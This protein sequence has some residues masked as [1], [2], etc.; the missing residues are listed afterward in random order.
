MAEGKTISCAC[1]IITPTSYS[2]KKEVRQKEK[3]KQKKKNVLKYGKL[4]KFPTFQHDKQTTSYLMFI[5]KKKT[6]IV[7]FRINRIYCIGIA[8]FTHKSV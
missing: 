3:K 5:F 1:V 8:G 2:Q 4:K 6:C 7:P